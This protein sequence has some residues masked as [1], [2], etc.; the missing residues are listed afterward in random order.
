MLK[1][2][3][4]LATLALA[5]AVA[6]SA[7]AGA[8]QG[9]TAKI[10][11][12]THIKVISAEPGEP[13][14]LQVSASAA[15]PTPPAGNIAITVTSGGSAARGARVAAPAVFTTTVH[16]T[17]QPVR[18][19]G[20]RLPKGGYLARAALSPDDTAKFLPSSDTTRFRIGSVDGG[21]DKSGALPNTGGPDL[22]WLLLGGAL[23][24]AGAGGVGYGRR[25]APAA[26]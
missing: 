1:K 23:V 26:A 6:P 14:V 17:D 4:A 10:P 12:A 15:N 13:I 19:T 9:Y 5:F 11:T 7:P 16:F 8:D 20:P 21:G 18:V 2:L 24:A 22:M 3:A 25:R